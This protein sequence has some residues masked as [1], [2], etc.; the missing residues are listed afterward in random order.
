MISSDDNG[1]S[2]TSPVKVNNKKGDA[3]L[4]WNAPPIRFGPDNEVFVI[5]NK[6]IPDEIIFGI[7][8]I[9]MAKSVDGGKTFEPTI[10]PAKEEPISEKAF[11]DLAITKNGTILIPY[12][13]NGAGNS[14]RKCFRIRYEQ[15]RLQYSD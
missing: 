9:R 1:S 3:D 6:I 15:V 10:Q 5:W 2:F 12:V 8:D 11:A 7:P 13:N 14:Q 4:P